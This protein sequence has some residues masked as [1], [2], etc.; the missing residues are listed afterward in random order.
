MAAGM[1]S[2]YGGLKQI[3][4]V[5]S[6]GEIIMDFSLY[7]AMLA[8]FEKAVFIIKKEM[9]PDMREIMD[10]GAARHI[11]IQYAFQT[12]DDIPEGFSVPEGRVK[13]WGTC[14]AVL[15][16][17]DVAGGPIAVINADD[18]Y[19]TNAF[20]LMY[21]YLAA[22]KDD[23]KLRYAMIGYQLKNTLTEHGSVARGVCVVDD[24]FLTK[25]DER[26]KIFWR[27]GSIVYT[28]DDEHFVSVPKDSPVSMNFWGF[29]ESFMEEL[30]AGF[31]A[32]LENDVP[33]NPLRAE[34]LLP[35]KVDELIHAGRATV[36]VIGTDDRW[37][38]VTYKED[39]EPTVAALQS[40]KDSGIY[41]DKLWR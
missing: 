19:G 31:P 18:Y 17:R 10:E 13:P 12:V 29:T 7:D 23:D 39:K 41:P 16:A 6:H 3:D 4:P 25:I 40:L 22:A 33:K 5:G 21:D 20:Q 24:G 27:D 37:Y 9:E 28:E 14:H 11:D 32:F 38:G 34:Y 1:G 8:G 30:K 35:K 2:R 36:K 15:A 26:L